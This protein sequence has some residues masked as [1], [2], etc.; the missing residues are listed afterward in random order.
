M[1]VRMYDAHNG[2]IKEVRNAVWIA[3]YN[4]TLRVKDNQ[5]VE[6]FIPPDAFEHY[7]VY[8]IDDVEEINND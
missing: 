3:M 4:G 8:V 1:I 6:Y 5:D 2:V 7:C